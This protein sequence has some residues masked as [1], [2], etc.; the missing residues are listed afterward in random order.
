MSPLALPGR[1]P[2]RPSG[3]LGCGGFCSG[4]KNIIN[5]LLTRD[6]DHLWGS[7]HKHIFPLV[8]GDG[9]RKK[10]FLKNQ[11][12]DFYSKRLFEAH[13]VT[14]IRTPKEFV[15]ES[16]KPSRFHGTSTRSTLGGVV[17]KVWRPYYIIHMIIC[18][19]CGL[20]IFH[21][22][23]KVVVTYLLCALGRPPG[24]RSRGGGGREVRL[25]IR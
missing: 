10:N 18:F 13:F 8:K 24:R 23:R 15:L 25:F 1:P 4:L 12:L 19:W 7:A 16:R 20:C 17:L 21:H 22:V 5:L 14:P 6:E 11:L 3:L 9:P 2:S